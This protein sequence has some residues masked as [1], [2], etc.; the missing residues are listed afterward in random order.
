MPEVDASRAASGGAVEAAEGAAGEA[1]GAGSRRRRGLQGM[2]CCD[3]RVSGSRKK[4]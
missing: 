4:P 2:G 3:L 1:D